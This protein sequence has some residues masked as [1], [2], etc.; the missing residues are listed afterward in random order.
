MNF[1]SSP[2]NNSFSILPTYFFIYLSLPTK[3]NHS[4]PTV[5][6]QVHHGILGPRVHHTYLTYGDIYM[7][8]RIFILLGVSKNRIQFQHA[9]T[10]KL[11]RNVVIFLHQERSG[12]LAIECHTFRKILRN[13]ERTRVG[14]KIVVKI[15]FF[16]FLFIVRKACHPIPKSLIFF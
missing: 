14:W 8:N 15:A 12:F 11:S 10:R 2:S 5:S 4:L 13:N 7:F 1:T 9:I 6:V 16:N 3:I